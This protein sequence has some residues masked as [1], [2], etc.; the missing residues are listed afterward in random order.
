MDTVSESRQVLTFE[1]T[2]ANRSVNVIIIGLIAVIWCFLMIT[3]VSMFSALA[4]LAGASP[5]GASVAFVAGVGVAVM[6][7]RMPLR[8]ARAAVGGIVL[9]AETIRVGRWWPVVV[10]YDQ[11]E[12]VQA[13]DGLGQPLVDAAVSR[14]WAIHI[15]APGLK[16]RVMLPSDRAHACLEALNDRCVGAVQIGVDGRLEPPG[17]GWTPERAKV[18]R[19]HYERRI[20][21]WW[22]IILACLLFGVSSVGIGFAGESSGY[23]GFVFLAPIPGFW[24]SLKTARANKAELEL[25]IGE[26]T[27]G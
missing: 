5:T 15:A 1:E 14:E 7:S 18:A 27:Q 12:L 23:A 24:K 8:R 9:D 6:L 13:A 26:S 3:I 25:R 11:V 22:K 16:T 4:V 19:Q 17:G 20:S 10:A 21:L 2:P